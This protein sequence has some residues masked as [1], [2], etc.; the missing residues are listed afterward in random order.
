MENES[1]RL[2]IQAIEMNHLRKTCEG[3]RMD[4]ESIE[5]MCIRGEGME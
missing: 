1:Q 5:N 4:G 3:R 2:I